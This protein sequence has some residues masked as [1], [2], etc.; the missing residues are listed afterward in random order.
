MTYS[1]IPLGIPDVATTF[2]GLRFEP[3]AL[4]A[5]EAVLNIK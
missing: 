5:A 4:G 3:I 2:N 1:L